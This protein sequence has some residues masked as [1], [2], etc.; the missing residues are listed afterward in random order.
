MKVLIADLFSL[1][2]IQELSSAGIEVIYN[3]ELN[4]D[5]LKAVIQTESPQIVVVRSTKV[6]SEIILAAKSVELI[7]RAGAGVDNIDITAATNQAIYVA[8][9]PGKNS[10]AVAELVMGHIIS[11]DRRLAENYTLL[12]QGK[13]NK[14]LFSESIGLKGRKIGIIGIGNIGKE[15][16]VRARSFG[17][18][19]CGTDPMLTEERARELGFEFCHTPEEVARISDIITFH[20]PSTEKTRGMINSAFIS[21]CKEQVTL[22]NTSRG[23]IV[24]E[25]ELLNELNNRPGLWYA[26]DVYKG[27][28]AAKECDFVSM[29]AQ[30]PKVYGS[31]HIGAS[32]KQSENAIG[33][34]ALRIIL[35][36]FR[37][38]TVDQAN[39][40]NLKATNAAKFTLVVRH[41]TQS[42]L[43]QVLSELQSECSITVF[44]VSDIHV[45]REVYT[46]TITFDCNQEEY[47]Y[48]YVE[49]LRKQ[50]DIILSASLTHSN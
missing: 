3:H 11:V 47:V 36:Y 34:E 2:A 42:V 35:Q 25:V 32:T 19:I 40:V 24:N 4:G 33:Q 26:C 37:T 44:N 16:A 13:W 30:H 9:C 45:S 7:I 6:T 50:T 29:L 15:V 41:T 49:N 14:G 18:E 10:V 27:E 43:Q 46:L 23:D 39:L 28:P 38:N 31:H 5:S 17:M 20:V 22:V 21:N 1:A 48:T 12:K 8:N